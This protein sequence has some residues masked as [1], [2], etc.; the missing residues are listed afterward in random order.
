MVTNYQ[1]TIKKVSKYRDKFLAAKTEDKA[2][3][4]VDYCEQVIKM[5]DDGTINRREAC[6][7]IADLMFDDTISSNPEL[8][9]I[10]LQA[11]NLEL[12]ENI[13]SG[14]SD[15]E[16]ERLIKWIQEARVKH[17]KK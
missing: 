4:Y 6:Y 14:N 12:P 10:A 5:F 2:S 13:V 17:S 1:N 8:E 3:A 15:A 9:S 11:G 16:W 7:A